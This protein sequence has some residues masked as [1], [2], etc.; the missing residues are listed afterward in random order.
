MG[1]V[2]I[3]K[4]TGLQDLQLGAKSTPRFRKRAS[5]GGRMPRCLHSTYDTPADT[6]VIVDDFHARHNA[7]VPPCK[8]ATL[9]DIELECAR[10]HANQHR[11]PA[12]QNLEHRE[13]ERESIS[14]EQLV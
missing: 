11:A 6:V 4:L 7:V 9:L 13:T 8:D 14:V 10:P 3:A 1:D 5:H 12:L 2:K